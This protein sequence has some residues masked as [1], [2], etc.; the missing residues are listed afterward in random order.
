MIL[1]PTSATYDS[2]LL[3][4]KFMNEHLF[5]NALPACLITLGILKHLGEKYHRT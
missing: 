1:N 2:L 5:A 3:A 4:Y